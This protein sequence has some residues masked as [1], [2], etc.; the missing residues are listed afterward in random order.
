[1]RLLHTKALRFEE[2]F[3]TQIPGYA[4]LSHRWEEQEVTFQ[5]FEVAKKESWPG[6]VKISKCCSLAGSRGFSW[7][8]IDTC[9][10]D[11]KSSAELSEAINSMFRLYR[12]AG[13]CYAYLSDVQCSRGLDTKRDFAQSAWFTRGWTLQE[14]LAPSNVIFLDRRWNFIGERKE[15][16]EEISAITGIGTRYFKDMHQAS[17]ATKMSWIS[18]RQTSRVEDMAYCLLGIFDVHMPLLYGEGRKAF[19]RLEIEIVKKSDDESIFA[20]TS[21]EW[22]WGL[23]AL[24]P[25]SFADSADI[26]APHTG[27]LYSSNFVLDSFNYSKAGTSQFLERRPYSMTNKGLELTVPQRDLPTILL[28][29]WK[30]GTDGRLAMT[31]RLDRLLGQWTRLN[32]E[33]LQFIKSGGVEAASMMRPAEQQTI[34]IEQA[35]L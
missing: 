7:V 20:W 11:K 13:E 8:W 12:E 4:V 14:L 1:M 29:C 26:E 34:Y 10:I 5:D 3:D 33:K 23:L 21:A 24:W 16:V 25:D 32:C 31:I 18:R 2:F 6:F 35:G 17:V 22:H 28:N 15:L 19:L 30:N 27:P 9:C